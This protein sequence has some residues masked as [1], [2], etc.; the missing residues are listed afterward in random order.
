[1]T[2]TALIGKFN[3]PKCENGNVLISS[4]K[5]CNSV[6]LYKN[7]KEQRGALNFTFFSNNKNEHNNNGL[8]LK[9]KDNTIV[10]RRYGNLVQIGS[11]LYYYNGRQWFGK[12]YNSLYDRNI[13][14]S[15]IPS[16]FN[17][18]LASTDTIDYVIPQSPS[19]PTITVNTANNTGTFPSS[20]V[21]QQTSGNVSVLFSPAA[22]P[23]TVNKANISASNGNGAIRAA[24]AFVGVK[25]NKGVTARRMRRIAGRGVVF[26]QQTNATFPCCPTGNNCI[27]IPP[28][29]SP[30]EVLS[31]RI[32]LYLAAEDR[33][34]LVPVSPQAVVGVPTI[35]TTP[36]RY[37][38][39]PIGGLEVRDEI[40]Y[41]VRM[42]PTSDKTLRL[43][44]GS[45]DVLANPNAMTT[46]VAADSTRAVVVAG[47][48]TA[49]VEK[50]TATGSSMVLLAVGSGE[51]SYAA[52][53][54]GPQEDSRRYIN[55][56]FYT[57]VTDGEVEKMPTSSSVLTSYTT[58]TASITAETTGEVAIQELEVESVKLGFQS[59]IGELRVRSRPY[60]LTGRDVNGNVVFDKFYTFEREDVAKIAGYVT[61]SGAMTN[62]AF[63]RTV[64]G[65]TPV[66]AL[67]HG[68]TLDAE[69]A[70]S[71][72]QFFGTV[73]RIGPMGQAEELR[74]ALT[75][76]KSREPARVAQMN[77]VLNNNG[78]FGNGVLNN[79]VSNNNGTFGN[80]ISNNG[81]FGNG[82]SNNGTFGNGIFGSDILNNDV[83]NNTLN[84]N[85]LNNGV[86]NDV[87]TSNL[88]YG[89]LV[90]ELPTDFLSSNCSYES[91][92][93]VSNPINSQLNPTFT[94]NQINGINTRT[95]SIPDFRSFNQFPFQS[96][97]S[98]SSPY[99]TPVNFPIE[100]SSY[101][102]DQSLSRSNN[103]PALNV[104][105]GNGT[106]LSLNVNRNRGVT[107]FG[108]SLARTRLF[109]QR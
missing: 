54:D 61:N 83:L 33:G 31:N 96:S 9:V 92:P 16:P 40:V 94:N 75:L 68:Q 108:E 99:Q 76:T 47:T 103:N 72:T 8:I 49:F 5:D 32:N 1:M 78:T 80:G 100:Q 34:G 43:T 12:W 19:T 22:N 74:G 30:S 25:N 85:V 11:K 89:R 21:G 53:F 27:G 14:V 44:D 24:S 77:T 81:T 36:I 4:D 45:T 91:A 102:Y 69:I 26:T 60:Y 79:G 52:L 104:S 55:Y 82:I 39:S 66:L 51:R 71:D 23:N 18:G 6:K 35:A 97:S 63:I 87:I 41:T 67:G 37:H 106:N 98:S 50:D 29:P 62:L 59:A 7:G 109:Q 90:P 28:C 84:N 107:P 86:L 105:S 38:P 3:V 88:N 93:F 70:N 17:L 15:A 65:F 48:A 13:S 57:V 73:P 46:V 64:N 2:Q 56:G 42:E 20:T 101:D 58:N 10:S 95:P